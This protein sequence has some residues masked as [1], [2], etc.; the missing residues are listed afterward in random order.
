M[1]PEDLS[2]MI[3]SAVRVGLREMPPAPERD[4]KKNK[5]MLSPKDIEDEYGIASRLLMY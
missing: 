2:E 3:T 1:S 5:K 4:G